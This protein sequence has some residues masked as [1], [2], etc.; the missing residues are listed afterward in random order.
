MSWPLGRYAERARIGHGDVHRRS[1]AL[2]GPQL[3]ADAAAE[4]RDRYL[5]AGPFSTH[6]PL[7]PVAVAGDVTYSFDPEA[8]RFEPSRVLTEHTYIAF[9]GATAY[10][11]RSKI[12]FRVTSRN[13]QESDRFLAG[14][15]TAFGAPTRAIPIDGVG[16][17]D[18]V[19]LG[20]FRRPRIEG[21]FTGSEMRAWDVNW[22]D[23]R[24]RLRRREL[25]RQ[26]QPRRDPHGPVA[27]GRDR[28][29]LARLSARRRRRAD[30]TRAS[31][32]PSGRCA[33][34]REAFDLQDY[35]VDGMLSG[36]FHV[37]G[38]Y[39]RPHGFGSMTIARGIAYDEPFSEATASLQFEGDGVR[40]NG[41]EMK[42][43]GGTVNGAAYVGWAGTYSF[44]V[45]GRGIA[46][47][48]L[49]LTA[50]PGYPAL[51]RIARLHR[52]RRRHVRGAALRRQV[53]R[54]RLVL[55][56]RGH[57]RDDR[58]AVDARPADD[59]RA[60][61]GVAAAGGV[62]H[63]PHRAQRRDGRG[64][65]VPRHRHVARSVPA[66]VAADVLAVHVGDRQRHHSRRRRALQPGCAAHRHQRRS[67]STCSCSI[68]GCATSRRFA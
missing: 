9:E 10:G 30:S 15:M 1:A 26:H 18:G 24:R 59:L 33:D 17:F 20:A 13:W 16:K 50:F 65:V 68:T 3:R 39:E 56:R 7:A 45:A 48:T 64:A 38:D 49:T 34:F 60:R 4:A 5:I 37:Y 25:V 53:E 57:R 14:I 31:A 43:G 42:K 62:G 6:T 22:G 52:H 54:Q 11:E 21:R 63:R 47:D 27:H 51:Y 32:S 66:R 28:A 58:P 55:R 40:L 19:M 61:S 67:R 29:V 36:D 44:D 12:P 46:V 2:Q 8:I 41:I 23:D 35:D